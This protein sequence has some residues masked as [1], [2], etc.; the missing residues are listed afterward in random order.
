MT[1]YLSQLMLAKLLGASLLLGIGFGV[2]YDLFRIRRAAFEK[3]HLTQRFL[4]KLL[5]H[6]EDLLFGLTAGVSTAILYFALSMGRIRLM[7]ILGEGV[8]FLLYRQTV[9]RLVMACTD[10]ILRLLSWVFRQIARWIILPPFRFAKRTAIAWRVRFSGLVSNWRTKR[11]HA[12]SQTETVR[13]VK[14]LR[15]LAAV[16][17]HEQS[18]ARQKK[19]R[20]LERNRIAGVRNASGKKAHRLGQG[21]ESL[22]IVENNSRKKRKKQKDTANSNKIS[23][24]NI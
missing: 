23:L 12:C 4:S 18:L 6:T 8:G 3:L 7:A 11:L 19:R 24:R 17:F 2:L 10:Q 21:N 15:S 9:G 5:L 13:Y 1:Q 16:G 14:T 20:R 22:C